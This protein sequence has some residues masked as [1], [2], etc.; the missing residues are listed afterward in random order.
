MN[1]R[2]KTTKRSRK[3]KIT[4]TIYEVDDDQRPEEYYNINIYRREVEKSFADLFSFRV[5]RANNRTK[6]KKKNSKKR[7]R[8]RK[9]KKITE[10]E[11]RKGTHK[12]K[13]SLVIII[14]VVVLLWQAIVWVAFGN[15]RRQTR[16][17]MVCVLSAICVYIISHSR[18]C[19]HFSCCVCWRTRP[20]CCVRGFSMCVGPTLRRPRIQLNGSSGTNNANKS[21]KWAVECAIVVGCTMYV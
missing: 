5:V 3:R 21:R 6:S 2:R 16:M 9:R 14:I 4:F 12:I 10:T 15:R 19:T 17:N 8:W 1:K 13:V 7:H 20:M 11:E 18:M